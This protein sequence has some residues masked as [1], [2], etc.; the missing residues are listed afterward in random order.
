MKQWYNIQKN[1]LELLLPFCLVFYKIKNVRSLSGDSPF[2]GT[3]CVSG[4]ALK[5]LSFV[6]IY[7]VQL[8]IRNP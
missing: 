3:S 5:K 1:S 2:G 6:F 8:T 4:S 7:F